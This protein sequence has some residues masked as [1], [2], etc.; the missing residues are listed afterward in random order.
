MLASE[1]GPPPTPQSEE[2]PIFIGFKAVGGQ[3]LGAKLSPI[4]LRA[5]FYQGISLVVQISSRKP[6]NRKVRVVS[7]FIVSLLVGSLAVGLMIIKPVFAES[8]SHTS[9]QGASLRKELACLR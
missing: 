5:P 7:P 6:L 4:R 9:H 3:I 1:G 8:C 2:T